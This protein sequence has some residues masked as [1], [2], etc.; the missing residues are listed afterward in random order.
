MTIKLSIGWIQSN[1]KLVSAKHWTHQTPNEWTNAFVSYDFAD[2]KKKLLNQAYLARR[3]CWCQIVRRSFFT[4]G[5]GNNRQTGKGIINSNLKQPLKDLTLN[6]W[7]N[8]YVVISQNENKINF[9]KLSIYCS[10]IQFQVLCQ[11]FSP[12]QIPKTVQLAMGEIQPNVKLTFQPSIERIEPQY[13]MWE[14]LRCPSLWVLPVY[15]FH[16]LLVSVGEL[17]GDK[18]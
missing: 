13:R 16:S 5:E 12:S 18:L 14:Y 7:V 17:S 6:E 9:T 1:S 10:G 8:T 4:A 2:R 3:R 11:F 15:K